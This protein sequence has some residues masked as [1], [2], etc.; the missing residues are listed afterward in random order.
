LFPAYSNTTENATVTCLESCRVF[1]T[2]A[3]ALH[4]GDD[5]DNLSAHYDQTQYN[6]KVQT[7]VS[8]TFGRS[9][10]RQMEEALDMSINI[11]NFVG[12]TCIQR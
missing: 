7:E 2:H 8:S 4:V 10:E 6:R 1:G 5:E 3:Y 11:S 12:H 9:S